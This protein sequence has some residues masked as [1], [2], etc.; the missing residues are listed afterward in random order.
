MYR[1]EQPAIDASF[2]FLQP[3]PPTNHRI[4]SIFEEPAE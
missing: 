1:E 4:F 3:A 2:P